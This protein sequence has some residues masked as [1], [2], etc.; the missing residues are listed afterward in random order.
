MISV[1]LRL[2]LCLC[3]SL[4]HLCLLRQYSGFESRHPSKIING[5]HKQ[6][7]G[8]H[9]LA[10]QKIYKKN[11]YYLYTQSTPQSYYCYTSLCQV[12]VFVFRKVFMYGM[13][14]SMTLMVVSVSVTPSS[15]SMHRSHS[16]FPPVFRLV[17]CIGWSQVENKAHS[18]IYSVNK[19]FKQL[20]LYI[21]TT[22]K[23]IIIRN[24]NCMVS[25]WNREIYTIE[26]EI[27]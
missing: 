26:C 13:S 5:R 9:T 12:S 7:S 22:Y 24:V 1:C 27:C 21:K 4:A 25:M 11:V 19:S 16:V 3:R 20:N 14:L 23:R 17:L 6:M 18:G 15:L 8:R 2:R 10:R